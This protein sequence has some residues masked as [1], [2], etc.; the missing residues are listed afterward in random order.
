VLMLLMTV[1]VLRCIIK[2]LPILKQISPEAVDF[3]ELLLLSYML[4]RAEMMGV[5]SG[6]LNVAEQVG[7]KV[8]KKCHQ[9][10]LCTHCKLL[11]LYDKC[12]E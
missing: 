1:A 3:Q 8:W 11:T 5:S 2:V 9:P 12:K 10:E 4:H 6:C 7:F